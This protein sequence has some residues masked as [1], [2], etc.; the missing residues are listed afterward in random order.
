MQ[1]VSLQSAHM[2]LQLQRVLHRSGKALAG[3]SWV[4]LGRA[5]A[6]LQLQQAVRTV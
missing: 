2:P 4:L 6:L 3:S 1:Q 5:H